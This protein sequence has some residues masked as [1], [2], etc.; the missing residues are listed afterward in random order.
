[1]IKSLLNSLYLVS[2]ESLVVPDIS[3]T[4]F[5]SSLSIELMNEDFPTLGL[6]SIDILGRFSVIWFS[7]LSNFVT[8]LSKSSPVPDPLI[9]EIGTIGT[10][11]NPNL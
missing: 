8:T 4:I 7:K 3:V 2:I 1:M 11:F 6:P 10:S 5:L 9:E